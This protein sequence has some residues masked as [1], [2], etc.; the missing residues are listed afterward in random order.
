MLIFS[1]RIKKTVKRMRR[2]MRRNKNRSVG[3]LLWNLLFHQTHLYPKHRIVKVN[4]EPEV[5]GTTCQI[6]HLCQMEQKVHL[7]HSRSGMEVHVNSDVM[8]CIDTTPSVNR[9]LS[10]ALKS[11]LTSQCTKQYDKNTFLVQ[12]WLCEN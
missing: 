10:E 12:I 2:K 6:P 4:Q 9:V 3:D 8:Q 7:V 5:H 1:P 11:C